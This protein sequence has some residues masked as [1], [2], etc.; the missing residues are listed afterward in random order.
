MPKLDN[1]KLRQGTENIFTE[2]HNYLEQYVDI[3]LAK[4]YE[5]VLDVTKHA[6][7]RCDERGI[8]TGQMKY[9]IKNFTHLVGIQTSTR[10]NF[11]RLRPLHKN[12]L[13]K[14]R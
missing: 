6:Q 11:Y 1:K 14:M 4:N 3:A 8:T 5:L 2:W 9:A 13:V 10:K 7:E 12:H